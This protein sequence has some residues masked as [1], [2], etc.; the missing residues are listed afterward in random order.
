[1]STSPNPATVLREWIKA[2][3]PADE[4]APDFDAQ[5]DAWEAYCDEPVSSEAANEAYIATERELRKAVER[6]IGVKP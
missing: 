4:L 3:V 2:N 5:M 1:M 6:A